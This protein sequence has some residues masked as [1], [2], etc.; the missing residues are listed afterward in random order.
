MALSRIIPTDGGQIGVWQLTETSTDLLAYFSPEELNNSDFWKYNYEKR[1]VEW[2]A[3]RAL[4][5]QMIG[6]DF[7]ISYSEVGKPILNHS[8]YK[9]LSISHS[10]E[11][12]AV[13]IHQKSDVG[14]DLESIDRNYNAVE[15]RYLSDT[16]LNQTGRDPIL[17]CL[18]WCAKEAIFK[19][20]QYDGLEFRVHIQILPFNPEKETQFSGCFT[21]EHEPV[22]FS[23]NFQIFDNNCMVWVSK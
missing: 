16:E 15:K 9:Y 3:T 21:F 18:Y 1:K 13:F 7:T 19:L 20:V 17:Q 2:L 8:G 22:L 6:S 11:F 5:K 12:V 10:R 4:I 23:L 14:I